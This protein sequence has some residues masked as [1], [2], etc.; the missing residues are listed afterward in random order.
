MGRPKR[1][2]SDE[3]NG[4]IRSDISETKKLFHDFYIDIP[5]SDWPKYT[6]K[7]ERESFLIWRKSRIKGKMDS[8]K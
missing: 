3:L 1:E 8:Y 4:K 2:V 5:M 6:K 7:E